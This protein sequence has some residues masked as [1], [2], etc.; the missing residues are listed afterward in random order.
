MIKQ[1]PSLQR[2]MRLSLAVAAGFLSYSLTAQ[3][4]YYS[5]GTDFPTS[6]ANWNTARDGSGTNGFS[7]T[8]R[9]AS[10][11]LVITGLSTG[12]YFNNTSASYDSFDGNS[13]LFENGSV[14]TNRTN[15]SNSY[16]DWN[17]GDLTVDTGATF[18]IR[19]RYSKNDGILSSSDFSGGFRGSANFNLA[20]G[21][22]LLLD[23]GSSLSHGTFDFGLNIVGDGT[24]DFDFANANLNWLF[25]GLTNDFTGVLRGD[26]FNGAI[27]IADGTN[28]LAAIELGRG[29][30]TRDG[31]IDLAGQFSVG[32]LSIDNISI[33]SGVYTYE[34]L[35]DLDAGFA[36]NLID[37]GGT[38][39][40]GQAIPEPSAFA[41]IAG[42]L[43]LAWVIVR[44]RK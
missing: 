18:E 32:A 17:G 21:S 10:N 12:M 36:N 27:Q 42:G 40:I 31:K 14:M 25:T 22:I 9:S 16:A 41:L 1:T 5:R 11:D 2:T 15:T 35:V 28:T 33:A 43:G 44:R 19:N 13:Y 20:S 7:T 34:D 6:G 3:I 29:D 8:Y 23:Q 38:I 4:T 24:I 37:N 30:G 26:T 39:Y